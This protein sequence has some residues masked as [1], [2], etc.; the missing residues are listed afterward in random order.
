MIHWHHVGNL[1][2]GS[3]FGLGM[4][5]YLFYNGFSNLKT[6]RLISG[7]PTSKARSL[8]MGIVELFG[9]A[10]ASASMTDPIYGLPCVFYDIC[11]KEERGA[12]KDRSWVKIY[13]NRSLLPFYLVDETG[14][15]LVYP[16]GAVHYFAK[17][18]NFTTNGI[19]RFFG[20]SNDPIEKFIST[21][22]RSG[23]SSLSI[24]AYL[25]REFEPLYVLGYAAPDESLLPPQIDQSPAGLARRLKADPER[26]K[27]LDENKDGI[28]D[29]SEWD[30]GLA[31]FEAETAKARQAEPAAAIPIAVRKS[32]EG[33]LVLADKPEKELLSRLALQSGFQ[34]IGGPIL[35]IACGLY[36]AR[37]F[38]AF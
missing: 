11:V 2:F 29:A 38:G 14:R 21:L 16:G 31:K 23:M 33:L 30:K 25:L 26:M 32:P 7:I 13:E 19:Q 22:N 4:G 15:V 12:G 35:A 36:I 9:R 34:I 1:D 5:V 27:A 20:T 18:V 17:D 24:E 37:L 28:I 8:A 3:F 10:G 6:G